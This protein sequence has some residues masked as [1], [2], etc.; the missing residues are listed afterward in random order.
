MNTG[1]TGQRCSNVRWKYL[2]MLPRNPLNLMVSAWIDLTIWDQHLGRNVAPNSPLTGQTFK[3]QKGLLCSA[4]S[5]AHGTKLY[6]KKVPDPHAVGFWWIQ[7]L[8]LKFSAYLLKM[9]IWSDMRTFSRGACHSSK[10]P[11]VTSLTI[12]L[13]KQQMLS[14]YLEIWRPA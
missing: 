14:R 8:K 13:V 7:I 5:S 4:D 1:L 12:E 9:W 3:V 10:W 11:D 2:K 6:N